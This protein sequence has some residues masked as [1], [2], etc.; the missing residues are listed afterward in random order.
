MRLNF[1]AK[2][3]VCSHG[4]WFMWVCKDAPNGLFICMLFMC[5]F[6]FFSLECSRAIITGVKWFRVGQEDAIEN[7]GNGNIAHKE[8]YG[9]WSTI[10][11]NIYSGILY[12]LT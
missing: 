6:L 2:C 12:F 8:P 11:I 5:A 4:G 9:L 3:V 1:C 10:F 7:F